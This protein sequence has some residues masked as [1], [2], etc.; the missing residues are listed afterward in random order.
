MWVEGVEVRR[1]FLR[2]DQVGGGAAG[3]LGGGHGAEHCGQLSAITI[4]TLRITKIN[5]IE[6][7]PRWQSPAR[8][9]RSTA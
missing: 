5:F 7:K 2:H 4:D 9:S 1:A 8:A 3:W 6:R